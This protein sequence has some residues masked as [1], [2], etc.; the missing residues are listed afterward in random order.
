M[1]ELDFETSEWV[2]LHEPLECCGGMR[3]IAVCVHTVDG[4]S[5]QLTLTQHELWCVAAPPVV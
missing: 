3:S 5:M 1:D 4:R 2:T